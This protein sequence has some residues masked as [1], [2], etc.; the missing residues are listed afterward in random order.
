[1]TSSIKTFIKD[2]ETRRNKFK[3]EILIIQMIFRFYYLQQ[4]VSSS[5]K[6][7]RLIPAI[8]W[9]SK[10]DYSN[11]SI[12]IEGYV[13]EPLPALPT[14]HNNAKSLREMVLRNTNCDT[15]LKTVPPESDMNCDI[16]KN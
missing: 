9:I 6:P 7:E 5:K 10:D 14:T 2:Y 3:V 1:M 4:R 16:I 13:L 11:G 12:D 8:C 15:N